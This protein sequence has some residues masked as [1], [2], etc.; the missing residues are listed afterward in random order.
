MR[1]AVPSQGTNTFAFGT[2]TARRSP[3]RHHTI[4]LKG[5]SDI[6]DLMSLA[7]RNRL[8]VDT[9]DMRGHCTGGTTSPFLNSNKS[10]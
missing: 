10:N 4:R 2:V 6:S 1:L 9:K 8:V 5:N 7:E 3:Q